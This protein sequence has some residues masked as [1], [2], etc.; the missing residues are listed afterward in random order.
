MNT[1]FLTKDDVRGL[2]SMVDVISSVEDAYRALSAS[3]VIQ[4]DYIGIH[5]PDGQAEIDF[6]ISYLKTT[7]VISVKAS[8]GGFKHNPE[9]Y[10]VPN[11]MGTILLFDG[12]NGRLACV[13]DGS[14][15]TGLRTGAAGAV[16]VRYLARK[17]ARV[18]GMIGAGNQARMQIRAIAE[19]MKIGE[20]HA[21]ANSAAS[22]Q[23]FK[24][25]IEAELGIPVT[26]AASARDVA[27]AADILIT[28]TRGK[29]QVVAADWVRPGTHII[30]IGADQQGKQ[31]LD[32]E[33]FRNAIIVV[34]STTQCVTKGELQHP[35]AAG[36]VAAVDIHAEIGQIIAGDKPGRQNDDQI[37]IFDSTGCAIQDNT[38]ADR[39][40][41]SALAKG[42]GMLFDLDPNT[43]AGAGK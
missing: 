34:D 38:T 39:I 31:E 25:D 23:A 2:T 21:V 12:K 17:S 3:Q 22:A 35:L 7:E 19:V 1:L 26:V 37:T 5:L 20:I 10:G 6:K 8:S 13:M 41:Q 30:A 32:P 4:P 28:T 18:L 9:R 27:H 36:V 14:L 15:I 24:R 29:G 33:L 43:V 40:Y 42:V 16:S 11:G